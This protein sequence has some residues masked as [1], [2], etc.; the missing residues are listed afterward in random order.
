MLLPRWFFHCAC[1][2]VAAAYPMLGFFRLD[3]LLI[4][5]GGLA[6]LCLLFFALVVF[7]LLIL[8]RLRIGEDGLRKYN[9]WEKSYGGQCVKKWNAILAG[10]AGCIPFRLRSLN[11]ITH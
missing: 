9:R 8:L 10:V 11:T 2:I 5:L 4:L 3:L 7:E 6:I 1:F